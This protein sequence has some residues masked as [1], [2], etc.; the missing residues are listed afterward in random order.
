MTFEEVDAYIQSLYYNDRYMELEPDVRQK[1]VFT[2]GEMLLSHY[3]EAYIT[4]KAQALQTLYMI[5]GESEEFALFKRQG[6]KSVGLKGLNLSFDGGT[7]SPE[8]IAVIE[9]TIA[10]KGKKGRTSVGRLI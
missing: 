4:P 8:A 3:D 2:A 6:V 9:K 5:E 7:I 10:D 1:V